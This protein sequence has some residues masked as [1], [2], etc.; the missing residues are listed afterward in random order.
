MQGKFKFSLDGVDAT[1]R[2]LA[3]IDRQL[4]EL[5]ASIGRS[6]GRLGRR[7]TAVEDEVDRLRGDIERLSAEIDTIKETYVRNSTVGE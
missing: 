5:P 7:V 1:A 2:R 4:L 6:V 3:D